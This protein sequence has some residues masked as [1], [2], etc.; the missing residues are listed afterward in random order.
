VEDHRPNSSIFS[1]QTTNI[2]RLI[3]THHLANRSLPKI[4]LHW[5]T[6]EEIDKQANSLPPEKP[7]ATNPASLGP[8]P[9]QLREPRFFRVFTRETVHCSLT[10]S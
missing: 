2:G 1:I 6:L 4:A 5:R 3:E 7:Y 10:H 9:A 8:A